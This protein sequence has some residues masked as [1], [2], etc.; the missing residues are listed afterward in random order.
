MLTLIFIKYLSLPKQIRLM[1]GF[2][3]LVCFLIVGFRLFF[4]DPLTRWQP[5]EEIIYL[6]L[7]ITKK[8][9]HYQSLIT[10][11]LLKK[12]ALNNLDQRL[13]KKSLSLSCDQKNCFL[14]IQ[15]N[16]R[17]ELITELKK[18]KISW[19]KVRHDLFI[20][21][22]TNDQPQLKKNFN[23]LNYFQKQNKF[24]GQDLKAVIKKNNQPIDDWQKIISFFE[25]QKING[26]ISNWGIE[27]TNKNKK[28]QPENDALWQLQEII[29]QKQKSMQALVLNDNQETNIFNLLQ[30]ITDSDF[31]FQAKKIKDTGLLLND[32]HF[33]IK[34]PQPADEEILKNIENIWLNWGKELSTKEKNLYLNDGTKVITLIKNQEL[35]WE[36]DN[37]NNNQKTIKINDNSQLYLKTEANQLIITNNLA[38]LATNNQQ[39]E[40]FG[41]IP[42]SQL[43]DNNPLKRVLSD[44]SWIYFNN[45]GLL[46]K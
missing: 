25:N 32:Y 43:N 24:L 15:T 35:N 42:L 21:S 28:I 5:T 9:N 17:S 30:N 45:N 37:Q 31:Y 6:N 40:S 20:I 22:E 33:L 46:I 1:A 14:F 13:I 26:R 23:P 34:L 18:E 38:Y 16:N 11:S 4:Y 39:K 19:Q 41:I 36:T 10:D 29:I 12:F 3:A 27:I 2:L 8:G 7:K 44:F